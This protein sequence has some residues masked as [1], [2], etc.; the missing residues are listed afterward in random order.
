MYEFNVDKISCGHCASTVTRAI[1]GADPDAKV[2]VII[3]EKR[4]KVETTETRDV[5]A[6]VLAEAG[7]PAQ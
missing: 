6:S 1:K 7:Y 2:E 4:V 3:P 5:I